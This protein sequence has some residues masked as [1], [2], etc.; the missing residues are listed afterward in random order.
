MKLSLNFALEAEFSKR[1][2]NV[3]SHAI[4]GTGNKELFEVFLQRFRV[5]K[6][7]YAIIAIKHDF[8]M[9]YICWVP[10]EV[11]K[12]SLFK[13]WFQCFPRG[14]ADVNVEKIMFDPYKI[15]CLIIHRPIL[16]YA[17][18]GKHRTDWRPP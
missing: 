15:Y 8:L 12:L 16:I 5:T 18:V 13:L 4:I 7:F 14:P 10:R 11:L 9:P 17:T 2:G 3:P 1:A 6:C